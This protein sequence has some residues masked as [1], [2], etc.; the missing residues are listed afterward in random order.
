MEEEYYLVEVID[1]QEYNIYIGTEVECNEEIQ[2]L[3]SYGNKN[4]MYLSI[5]RYN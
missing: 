2:L 5:N 3:R 1:E 4:V